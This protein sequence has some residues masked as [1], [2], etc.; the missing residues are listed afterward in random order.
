MLEEN[1][2]IDA[3]KP[4]GLLEVAQRNYTERILKFIVS[5]IYIALNTEEFVAYE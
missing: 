3:T 2:D 1:N 5:K 4:R